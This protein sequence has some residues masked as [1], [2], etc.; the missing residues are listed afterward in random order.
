MDIR[1]RSFWSHQAQIKNLSDQINFIKSIRIA[2]IDS[3]YQKHMDMLTQR[4]LYLEQ[5][6]ELFRR[7]WL[8]LREISKSRPESN[9]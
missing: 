6:D 1:D 3:D 2:I 7:N 4:L 5:G 8:T 9:N